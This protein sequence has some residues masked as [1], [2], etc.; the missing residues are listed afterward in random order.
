VTERGIP[1]SSNQHK[2]RRPT[3]QK[4]PSS[5]QTQLEQRLGINPKVSSSPPATQ[6][7]FSQIATSNNEE[8]P[9]MFQE[10][11]KQD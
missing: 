6:Q 2:P 7:D 11:F 9:G 10:V 8:T 5:Y 3:T 4:A 1:A